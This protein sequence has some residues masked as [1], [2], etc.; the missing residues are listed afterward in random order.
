MKMIVN[1]AVNY[2]YILP[3]CLAFIFVVSYLLKR[4]NRIKKVFNL[5]P[6]SDS[7]TKAF[8]WVFRKLIPV[9][10]KLYR[11]YSSVL[12]KFSKISFEKLCICKAMAFFVTLILI[13]LIKQTNIVIETKEIFTEVNYKT[14]FIYKLSETIDK[15]DIF[16][17]EIQYLSEAIETITKKDIINEQIVQMKIRNIILENNIETPI[18]VESMINRVYHRIRDYYEIRNVN[19][20]NYVIWALGFSFIPELLLIVKNM[21][22]KSETERELR[23]LK[24]LIIMNGSIKP[25]DF[26]TV[27]KILISKSKYYKNIL[28]D[29]EESNRLNSTNNKEIYKFRIK[30]ARNIEEK[31]FFEKLDEAN[32]YDFDQAINNIENEFK[33]E[34]RELARKIRKRI[35]SIH[36]SG[37]IGAMVIIVL[38]ILY[39]IIPWMELYNMKQMVF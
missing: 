29:I 25:V 21:Y 4:E 28:L 22:I 30:K 1:R 14:D 32:N 12:L 3:L 24:K 18:P 37:M 35:E 23:F 17:K 36:L 27:L 34:R 5:M 20:F 16:E 11:Y 31:I 39:L 38:M 13:L 7:K 19:F 2:F 26:L 9:E 6:K 15:T 33:L 10:S 8:T